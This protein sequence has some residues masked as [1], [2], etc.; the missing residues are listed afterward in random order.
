MYCGLNKKQEKASEQ[1]MTEAL[2]QAAI[3]VAKAVIIIEK[4][5]L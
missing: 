1:S 3:E 4:Q 2:T 5:K